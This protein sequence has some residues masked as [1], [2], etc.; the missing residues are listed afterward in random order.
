LK[1]NAIGEEWLNCSAF[2]NIHRE[3]D[4]TAEEVINIF[5]EKRRKL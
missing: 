3:I 4:I 2:L 5:A 1:K